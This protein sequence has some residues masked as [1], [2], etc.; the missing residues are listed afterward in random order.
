MKI[1]K[2][3]IFH[4]NINTTCQKKVVKSFFV[5]KYR[6][7]LGL[8]NCA[9]GTINVTLKCLTRKQT[10]SSWK[11]RNASKENTKHVHTYILQIYNFKILVVFQI[12]NA[13]RWIVLFFWK[14]MFFLKLKPII[15]TKFD[16]E[17]QF[18]NIINSILKRKVKKTIYFVQNIPWRKQ[19]GEKHNYLIKILLL[20]IRV[21]KWAKN[22]N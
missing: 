3:T 1:S 13:H 15:T 5:F 22:C 8:S 6:G 17:M 21:D 20:Y 14:E 4:V 19:N 18:E 9:I 11:T 10:R 7:N 12:L 16:W 2:E